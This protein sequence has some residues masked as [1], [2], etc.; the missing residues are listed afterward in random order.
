MNKVVQLVQCLFGHHQWEVVE[1]CVTHTKGSEL[2]SY[3]VNWSDW[4]TIKQ[5]R[6]CKACGVVG[7]T[8]EETT[9]CPLK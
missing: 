5:R 9:E 6:E 7:Y 4:W 8:T 1:R 2:P 3:F